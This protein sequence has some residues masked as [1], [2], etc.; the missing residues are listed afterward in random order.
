MYLDFVGEDDDEIAVALL[1]DLLG[2][3]EVG[4]ENKDGT[5]PPPDVSGIRNDLNLR[6]GVFVMFSSDLEDAISVT[7]PY[8][9]RGFDLETFL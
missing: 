7:D 6:G 2:L 9:R 4:L 8:A 3:E 5:P 1:L